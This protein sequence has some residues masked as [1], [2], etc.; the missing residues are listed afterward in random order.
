MSTRR[1]HGKVAR[2]SYSEPT[3]GQRG[4]T[5]DRSHHE[6]RYAAGDADV[7]PDSR[8]P[9][10]IL[11]SHRQWPHVK[12]QRH[13]VLATL[14]RYLLIVI[15]CSRA[16]SR[17]RV[18][19]LLILYLYHVIATNGFTSSHCIHLMHRKLSFNVQQISETQSS[20]CHH[21][22]YS[23]GQLFGN[24]M[25]KSAEYQQPQCSIIIFQLGVGMKFLTIF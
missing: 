10:V 15:Q 14:I 6:S 11:N 9:D 5:P 4:R 21:P 23:I 2:Y 3:A 7:T 13:D 25:G 1:R 20:I 8:V 19:L 12:W 17:Q 22:L 24:G 16:V 18:S